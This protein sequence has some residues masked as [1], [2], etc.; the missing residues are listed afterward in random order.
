MSKN[1]PITAKVNKGLFGQ[2]NLTVQEPLL[3]VGV[4]GVYGNNQTRNIPAPSKLMSSP[5]K[6]VSNKS[7]GAQIAGGTSA[8]TTE[9]K[10]IKGGT[11]T[12]SKTV[13][14][15]YVGAA[16]DACSAQYIAANGRGACDKYKAL[17]AE[18]KK[19]ANTTTVPE[20]TNKPD[21]TET[22]QKPGKEIELRVY[23]EGEAMSSFG[24]RQND[25]A[26]IHTARKTKRAEIDVAK[27]RAKSGSYTDDQGNTITISDKNK[28]VSDAKNAA[29]LKQAETKAKGFGANATN[30][31][32]QAEQSKSYGGKIIGTKVDRSKEDVLDASRVTALNMPDA[33][34]Q[35]VAVNKEIGT[36]KTSNPAGSVSTSTPPVTKAPDSVKPA[37][38]DVAADVKKEDTESA[39]KYKKPAF[40]DK[41]GPLKMKYF[42]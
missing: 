14:K 4:A 32:L 28:F 38:T 23:N 7:A 21:T 26:I 8:P 25:R 12:T 42:K 33:E 16:N 10:V 40:F 41:R 9:T 13:K 24:R 5:F 29:R 27:A 17:P 2:K 15:P 30:A 35:V 22:T 36:K 34:A 18:K 11:T 19:A 6:Q 37:A 39:A 1:I 20:T 31:V 3:S